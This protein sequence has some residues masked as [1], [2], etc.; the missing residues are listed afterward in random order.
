MGRSGA[1]GYSTSP[2]TLKAAFLVALGLVGGLAVAIHLFAP[3][4]MR[5]LGQALPG[6]R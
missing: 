6:G 4:A 5:H 1:R 2:M 3:E